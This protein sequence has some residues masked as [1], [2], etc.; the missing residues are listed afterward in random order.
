MPDSFKN[1]FDFSNFNE[2][3]VGRKGCLNQRNGTANL[4][5]P[6]KF[7]KLKPQRSEA[8]SCSRVE[9]T[10]NQNRH[11]VLLFLGHSNLSLSIGKELKKFS[12]EKKL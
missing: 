8:I 5:K 2:N 4:K 11:L 1:G 9:T 6:I 3:K 10:D 7:K 12:I